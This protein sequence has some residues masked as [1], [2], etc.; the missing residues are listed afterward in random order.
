MTQT[1]SLVIDAVI[2]GREHP[3]KKVVHIRTATGLGW[4]EAKRRRNNARPR[5]LQIIPDRNGKP[6]TGPMQSFSK[7]ELEDSNGDND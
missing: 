4:S 6:L 7:S 5:R 1:Y 2:T 3:N